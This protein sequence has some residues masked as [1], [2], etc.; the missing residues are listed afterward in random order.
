MGVWHGCDISMGNQSLDGSK[1]LLC[2]KVQ[3]KAHPK[4][5][6]CVCLC[7]VLKDHSGR[8]I[9]GVRVE[10]WHGEKNKML[11]VHASGTP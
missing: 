5:Q 4:I 9:G 6:M 10:H 1:G 8:S 7:M 2:E 3:L 11:Y